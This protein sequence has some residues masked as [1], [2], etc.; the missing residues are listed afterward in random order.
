[1]TFVQWE[2]PCRTD[3]LAGPPDLPVVSR[4]AVKSMSSSSDDDFNA[5]ESVFTKLKR[6]KVGIHTLNRERIKY[7]EYLHL[8]QSLKNDNQSFF[9]IPE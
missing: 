9:N 2:F 5:L 1:M 3:P 6:K 8:F 4:H 7:G